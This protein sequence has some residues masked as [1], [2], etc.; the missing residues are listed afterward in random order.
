MTQQVYYGVVCTT[1]GRTL[2]VDST[3]Y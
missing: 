2:G 3:G 1:V